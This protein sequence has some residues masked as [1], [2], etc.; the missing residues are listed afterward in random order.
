MYTRSSGS[1]KQCVLK[2]EARDIVR[3]LLQGSGF[4]VRGNDQKYDYSALAIFVN[5]SEREKTRPETKVFKK[6]LRQ[7]E[8]PDLEPET[9]T[10]SLFE[11]MIRA[12]EK[13]QGI[14]DRKKSKVRDYIDWDYQV[15]RNQK[16]Y[17]DS[18][19]NQFSYLDYSDQEEIFRT[20]LLKSRATAFS[21]VA[22]CNFTQQWISFRLRCLA[23]EKQRE[24][25]RSCTVK[26]LD[27]E[28]EESMGDFFTQIGQYLKDDRGRYD[29]AQI[30]EIL[31]SKESNKPIIITAYG[32]ESEDSCAKKLIIKE[33][34]KPLVTRISEASANCCI[35]LL[36]VDNSFHGQLSMDESLRL[37]PLNNLA[38]I[39]DHVHDWLKSIQ[40]FKGIWTA[41]RS[42]EDYVAKVQ[43]GLRTK[44]LDC[45]NPREL[46]KGL[47]K[48]FPGCND[49][50]RLQQKYRYGA[51]VS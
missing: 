43:E 34:W 28:T 10:M 3:N 18:V 5:P 35:I 21:I 39:D 37:F 4:F 47:Y 50:S 29:L 38:I 14:P 1:D 16:K 24:P 6:I 30:L 8:N 13:D 20:S 44:E 15:T 22:P 51:E 23:A 36:I 2:P 33:F 49:F 9:F 48:K 7:V 25:F 27:Y 12:L 17:L 31:C 19:A 40:E 32:F 45:A 41:G 42:S 11:K 26:V 46:I